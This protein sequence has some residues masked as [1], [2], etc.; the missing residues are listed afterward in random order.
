M[1]RTARFIGVLHQKCRSRGACGPRGERTTRAA[2][3]I[4]T[5]A[6]WP[7]AAFPPSGLT[8][9]AGAFV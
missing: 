5:L 2:Q 6:A 4:R 7:F 8:A 9:F 1:A 3:S